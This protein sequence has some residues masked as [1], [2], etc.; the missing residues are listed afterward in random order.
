M[1][2]QIVDRSP[3]A[4][5]PPWTNRG[6]LVYGPRKSGTTLFLNLLDGSDEMVAYPGELKVK[7]LRRMSWGD[8]AKE[9]YC[10]ASHVPRMPSGCLDLE[11][12]SRLW[13]AIPARSVSGNLS[14]L[15]RLD[16]WNVFQAAPVKARA[17]RMWCAKDVGGH[18]DAII[19]L[20][21]R[22]FDEHRILFI[23]RSPLIVTRAVLQD[24]RRK[25]IRLAWTQIVSEAAKPLRV[26]AAQ[27][28]H[29]DDEDVFTI[30]YEDLVARTTSTM[31]AVAWFLGIPYTT[32][33]EFPSSFGRPVVV[34]TASKQVEEVFRDNHHWSEG[35]TLR[36]KVLVGLTSLVTRAHPR[37]RL[38]YRRLRRDIR[39][40]LERWSL[41]S[42]VA[43]VS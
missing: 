34:T 37:Y 43:G 3:D 7:Y 5:L 39:K 30:C 10:R 36:E 41:K 31:R 4:A 29:I 40:R 8:D 33:F 14:K 42:D 32:T 23:V 25:G 20:W 38:N 6:V 27:H 18:T 2:D 9:T 28:R 13:A 24:R 16:I 17:P 35:L 21:R 15:M 22:C 11:M 1:P 12:Y 19:E 26:M